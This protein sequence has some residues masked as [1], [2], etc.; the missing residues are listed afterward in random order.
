MHIYQHSECAWRLCLLMVVRCVWPL[1]SLGIYHD[2]WAT[3]AACLTHAPIHWADLAIPV[4][5]L[6]ATLILSKWGIS[7]HERN[8]RCLKEE[9]HLS[10]SWAW[11]YCNLIAVLSPLNI[12]NAQ[13]NTSTKL[14][15][16]ARTICVMVMMTYC[17]TSLQGPLMSMKIQSPEAS[18]FLLRSCVQ[19]NMMKHMPSYCWSSGHS[20]GVFVRYHLTQNQIHPNCQSSSGSR[21]PYPWLFSFT[22]SWQQ[23]P[24][25]WSSCPG[26]HKL[27]PI[28][29]TLLPALSQA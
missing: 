1:G 26:K 17:V 7:K 18:S 27:M 21:L 20:L 3:V 14:W 23:P 25:W 22:V 10:C 2:V 5:G 12:V 16:L 4:G 28:R 11:H 6:A 15:C 29:A 24:C 8:L 13:V 19:Q 9:Q